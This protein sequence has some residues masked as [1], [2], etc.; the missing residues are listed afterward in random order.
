MDNKKWNHICKVCGTKYWAC[1]DCSSKVFQSW[2]AVA[3]CAEH[4]QVY[5]MLW[6]YDNGTVEK[7]TVKDL[8]I[9]NGVEDWV[10][11]SPSKEIINKVLA[12]DD[13]K[14]VETESPVEVEQKPI[15]EN[16]FEAIDK[17]IAESIA[18]NEAEPVV[19]V[20]VVEQPHIAVAEAEREK[21][22]TTNDRKE[23][24]G[25]QYYSKKHG[26]YN[27]KYNA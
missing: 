13:V 2:R 25:N 3:C 5:M 15:D 27:K 9:D 23:Y 19:E 1:N 17:A 20:A 21:P 14:P 16:S 6:E 7:Q 26:K 18:N 24:T 4:Y 22:A 8:L 10:N 11:E 12:D